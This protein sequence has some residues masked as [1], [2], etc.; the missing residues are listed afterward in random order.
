MDKYKDEIVHE[1]TEP[2]WQML[3]TSLLPNKNLKKLL[4][5]KETYKAHDPDILLLIE[6]G[7]S[8]SLNNFNKYFLDDAYEVFTSA[9][10]SDRGIDLGFM[11]KK[12]IASFFEFSAYVDN[13]LSNQKKFSR[14]VF[15]LKLKKEEEIKMIFLLTHLK[16]KLNLKKLDFEGRGQRQAET[17][18]LAKIYQSLKMKYPNAPVF[19]CGDLNGIYQKEA[20][21]EEYLPLSN[22]NLI[23]ALEFK[24]API[25]ERV[26][27]IYFDKG[28]NKRP[29]QL[30]YV[31]ASTQDFTRLLPQS[32]EIIN[33]EFEKKYYLT[34]NSLPQKE[35][36][37]SD[38][39][40][41][42][43]Q[44]KL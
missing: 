11:V 10:N 19:I 39:Y 32:T 26:S 16:S 14:G 12:E 29:M 23:D 30:D 8:E 24:K 40:P 13:L 7:G 20:Q 37:P 1:L 3:S 2:K 4:A 33:F 5:L 9:S 21:E 44:V 41:Y 43:F 36:L 17:M 42:F 25:E 15:E 38:H 34:P 18:E 31:L 28:G 22:L 27:Y 6:V 35:K